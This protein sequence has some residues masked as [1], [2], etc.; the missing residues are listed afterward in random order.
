MN[1]KLIFDQF[2]VFGRCLLVFFWYYSIVLFSYNDYIT[3]K[4]NTYHHSDFKPHAQPL[5]SPPLSI[6]IF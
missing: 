1:K 5:Q 6:R 3:Y 4:M 2:V